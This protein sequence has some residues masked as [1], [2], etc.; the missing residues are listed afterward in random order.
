MLDARGL[1]Q[2]IGHTEMPGFSQVR[3]EV[4]YC[5][6][7]YAPVKE[8]I[9]PPPLGPPVDDKAYGFNDIEQHKF[10]WKGKIVVI[11]VTP[12]ILG[13]Q[14][15]G[16]D[17][18]RAFLKDI[19]TPNHYGI[20]EFPHD[21]LVKLGFLKKAVSGRHAF[22]DLKKLGV[23]GR[24]EGKP[25]SFYVYVIPIGEKPAARAVAV[26]SKLVRDLDGSVSYTWESDEKQTPTSRPAPAAS[27][28]S[29]GEPVNR[30]IQKAQNGD[31][32]GAMADFD[33]AIQLNP[34]DDAPYYNRAQAKR[35]T[36]DTAGTI[37]DYTRAV[38]LGSANPAAYNNRGSIRAE[39]NDWDAAI[40]D[41]TRAIELESNYAGAYYNRAIAK[42]AKGDST[43]AEADFKT[44]EK[45]DPEFAREKPAADSKNNHPSGVTGVS[46]LGGK[47]KLDVPADLS[48]DPDNPKDP[49]MLARFSGPDG[50]WGE[51]L[52][53][54]HHWRRNSSTII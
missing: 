44:A 20:V 47:L 41:Y 1:A 51:V 40:A 39:T 46:L 12:K 30:G 36:N 7:D 49:K 43:G 54:T 48:R 52:R 53:G 17:T 14:Q 28:A 34:N 13:S 26:G 35:L 16:E 29:E 21:A 23:L 15:I 27:E 32:D 5:S 6:F 3:N 22:E 2:Y 38:E 45:L 25:V 10:D 19:A 18:Y 8:K 42:K 50:A 31:L 24:T 37:A 4:M 11:E 9:A 33:R